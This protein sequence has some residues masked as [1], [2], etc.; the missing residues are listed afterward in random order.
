MILSFNRL[1]PFASSKWLVHAVDGYRGEAVS[2]HAIY[3]P[4]TELI[5]LIL[6]AHTQSDIETD[7]AS[8]EDYLSVCLPASPAVDFST[9][10][11]E[12]ENGDDGGKE[13]RRES[14]RPTL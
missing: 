4:Q 11:N 7:D 9:G 5:G 2:V 3:P 6:F 1:D 14:P 10:S 13:T 12:S 8:E